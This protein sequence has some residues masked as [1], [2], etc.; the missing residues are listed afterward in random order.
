MGLWDVESSCLEKSAERQHPNTSGKQN[1][2]GFPIFFNKNISCKSPL[3]D[4]IGSSRSPKMAG[5]IHFSSFG[6]P[7][8]PLFRNVRHAAGFSVAEYMASEG[9]KSFLGFFVQ[10]STPPE[11]A[12]TSRWTGLAATAL[13]LYL[14]S[15][16][17]KRC[18]AR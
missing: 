3:T 14:A 4:D 7:P 8:I 2:R 18:W 13:Q 9:S 11:L 10:F 17:S 12:S 1:I 16:C 6:V 5:E 15:C